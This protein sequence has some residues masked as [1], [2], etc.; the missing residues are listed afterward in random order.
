MAHQPRGPE[1]TDERSAA[2]GQEI[3]AAHARAG[4]S[5]VRVQTLLLKLAVV[6]ALGVNG[7]SA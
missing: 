3:A 6:C 2:K 1:A 4:F 7:A 5:E